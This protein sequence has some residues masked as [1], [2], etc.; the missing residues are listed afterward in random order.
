MTNTKK[1]LELH[2]KK[3]EVKQQQKEL[4]IKYGYRKLARYTEKQT[5]ESSAKAFYKMCEAKNENSDYEK[6][7]ELE[8]DYVSFNKELLKLGITHKEIIESR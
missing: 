1:I 7:I 2:N 5:R 4:L 6:F 3:E 8:M